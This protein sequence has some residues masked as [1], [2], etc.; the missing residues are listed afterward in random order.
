MS[1]ETNQEKKVEFKWILMSAKELLYC[2]KTEAEAER[3]L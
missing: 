1:Y 2:F 3:S